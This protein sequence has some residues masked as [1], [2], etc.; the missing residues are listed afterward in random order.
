MTIPQANDQLGLHAQLACLWEATARKP[1]NVHRFR[2]FADTTYLDFAASAAV[3]GAV[4]AVAEDHGV[5]ATVCEAVR[6]RKSVARR[7]TN[8]GLALLLAPLAKARTHPDYRA[9]VR[10]VLRELTVEDAAQV[11]RAIASAGAGG[12]G[13]VAEQDVRGEPTVDL[14]QAMGLA[15][16]RDLVARQYA[17]DFAE[18]FDEGAPAILA[19]VERTGSIEGGIIHGHLHLM[20]KFPDSLIARKR[21]LEEASESARR[22]AAVLEAG[23]P[24]AERGR[25]LIVELDDW[26]RGAGNERNPGTTADLV[27]ASLFV[28]LRTGRLAP[29]SDVPWALAEGAP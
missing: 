5:G 17:D 24:H 9:G 21:G 27:G 14:R 3:M 25:R 11:Y 26:L 1:G 6:L 23:W 18:V 28:L 10:A 19:A 7:N 2:D 29:V 16:D 12:L 15:A 13:R 4:I 22:A 8:L 20:A